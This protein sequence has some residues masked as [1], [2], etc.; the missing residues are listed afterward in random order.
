MD[1][2]NDS[3]DLGKLQAKADIAIFIGYAPKK[4]AY[5]IYNRHA[6]STSILSS[7]EQEQ[8]QEHS[9]IISQGFEESPKMPHF[10]DDPLYESLHKDS[11]SQGSSS[12]VRPIHTPLE[13]LGRWTKDHPIA[14]LIR[15]PSHTPVVEKSKLDEDLQGKLVDATLY[16]GMIGSFMYLHPDTGMSLTAYADADHAGCQDTRRSTLGSAQFLGDKLVR[17]SSKKQKST[18]ISSTEVENKIVELYFVRTEYQL[19]DIFTKP[20]P[21]EI[22]YFLIEKLGTN[23]YNVSG[24]VICKCL[25]TFWYALELRNPLIM[26]SKAQQIELDNALVA[27]ENHCVM[28]KCNMRIN[29]GM[30]PKGSTYQVVLDALALTTCYPA[31][32]ITAKVLVIYMHHFWATVN[33]HKASYQFK[34]DNKKFSVNVEVFKDILNICPRIPGQELDEPPT[35]EES[36]S[37]IRELRH[38]REIIYITDV[39]VDHLH[40]PWRTFAL[41]INKC[42]RGKEDLAYQIDLDSKKQDKMFYPRFTKI[43]IH[44]FLEKDKSISLRNITNDES[45]LLDSVAYKTYFAIAFGAE[46]TK[47]R[48][49]QK[50]SNSAISYEESLSKKKSAKAKK[51]DATKTKPTKKKAPVKAD[52][53]KGLIVLTEVAL[54]EAAQL[55][56]VAKQSKKDFH[57]SHGSG[58]GDGTGFESGVHDE[59]HQKTLEEDDDDEDDTEDVEENNDSDA[60]NDDDG[61]DG[62]NG[63]DDD[64]ETDSD[65]T[66]SNRIKIPVLTSE[67]TTSFPVLSI[68]SYVFKFNDRVTN[69][70]KDLLEIKQIDQEEAQA[71]KRD[72]I[73]LVDTSMRDILKEEV[74]TQLPQILHQAVSDFATHVA[75]TSLFEFELTKILIDKMEKN[76]SYDKANYKREL[77]VALVKSYQTDKDLFDTYGKVFTLKRNRDA[78]DKGQDPSA[79]SDRGTKRRKSSKEAESSRN[80]RSKEKKS[81]STSKDASHSQ[82]KPS[83][84]SIHAKEPSHPVDDSG[85]QQNQEF[86]TGNNDEQPTD[87]ETWISQV[88]RA[89]EPTTSFDEL[90]NTLINFCAFILNRLNIKD[91]TQA[92]LVGSAFDLLKGTCKSLTGLEYHLKECSKALTNLIIDERDD[93]NVT[94]RMFTRRIVIQ[95][96]VEDLQ[97]GF[98]SYQKK[99]NL[100]KPDTFRSN[101]RNKTAYIAYLEPKGVIYKDQNNKNILMCADELHKFRDGTLNDV[102]TALHDIASGIKMEYLPKRKRSGLDKR[103]AWFMIQDIVKKLF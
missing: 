69:L 72:Y 48:K 32:L 4:K 9:P 5:R 12:N 81:S 13:S 84:K 29:P 61:N 45:R 103:R 92:I 102:W 50:K 42:L 63:D 100:T 47:S 36:L 19:A 79:G 83:G 17:W 99:L 96:R 6:P 68:F 71:E 26:T 46:P 16:R 25:T 22:F 78:R 35:E 86:D 89:K 57:I 93:L 44:H 55:K 62:N 64:E 77:Y 7:Q 51:V 74:N 65:R 31:F 28:G 38:Y 91:L 43:I 33:K 94:L 18:A 53:G 2:Y 97:L 98:E 15:D 90:L 41:I 73:E 11:T 82:H 52:R 88:A 80:S 27:P 60:N 87:K 54:S 34:I 10:H 14:N 23:M 70:E 95:R 75:T 85:V 21:R 58:S 59:K 67:T 40:Q 8:E 56:E 1:C 49:S 3:E 101:L 30:K 24:F 20:L 37:F 39:I 66:E 76:K